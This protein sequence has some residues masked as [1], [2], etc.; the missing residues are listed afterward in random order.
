LDSADFDQWNTFPQSF[1]S[2]EGAFEL[3][4]SVNRTFGMNGAPNFSLDQASGIFYEEFLRSR[5]EEY[6]QIEN[7]GGSIESRKAEI[8]SELVVL[9]RSFE[10]FQL[11]SSSLNTGSNGEGF[12]NAANP[13]V[14]RSY[15][16]ITRNDDFHID[17]FMGQEFIVDNL[18][19][20]GSGEFAA[21]GW[22]SL[23]ASSDDADQNVK[24][25]PSDGWFGLDKKEPLEKSDVG[26]GLNDYKSNY[27]I[28]DHTIKYAVF[29][30]DSVSSDT[31]S[32]AE[33]T[34][35]FKNTL[36][37]STRVDNDAFEAV[38]IDDLV[39]FGSDFLPDEF[40]TFISMAGGVDRVTGSR[41]AD[42]I[43]GPDESSLHGTMTFDSGKGDDFVKPGRG[44]SLWLLGEGSDVIAFSKGDLF[45]QSIFLDYNQEEDVLIYEKGITAEIDSNDRS[46]LYLKDDSSDAAKTILLSG[47]S[48]LFWSEQSIQ[49]GF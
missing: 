44:Q 10:N 45:G 37:A 27:A 11:A 8:I 20:P 14:G 19:I 32:A 16:E 6:V 23:I 12:S 26:G 38:R 5:L 25:Y 22:L 46:I 4:K 3:M 24:T 21:D 15:E 48:D 40:S 42:V 33:L 47:S 43:I 34:S 29:A 35:E 41:F 49:A 1:V 7:Q 28:N 9:V 31:L 2:S 13:L 17:T 18:M 39:G 36:Q 30:R